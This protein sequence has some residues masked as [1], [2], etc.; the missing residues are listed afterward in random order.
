MDSKSDNQSQD[1]NA[2]SN[3]VSA[4]EYQQGRGEGKPISS[5]WD[6]QERWTELEQATPTDVAK[7]EIVSGTV[8]AIE[9]Q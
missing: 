6:L 7:G 1:I 3:D 4:D 9:E 8:V 2:A 5:R